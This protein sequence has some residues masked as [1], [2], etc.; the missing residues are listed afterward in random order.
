MALRLVGVSKRFGEFRAVEEVSLEAGER[1]FVVLL[2]P[3][4]SGKSTLLR[5]IAGLEPVSAGEILINGRRVD[6]LEPIERNI[7]FVFQ[8]YALYP[9]MTVRRNIAFPLIMHRAR[10][11][12]HLPLLGAV[13]KR[14]IENRPE[15]RERT[16]AVA[17]SIGLGDMLDRY[18]RTLSGGQ[19]QRVAVGRALVRDPS[20]FLMDEPLSN[21]DA[22]LRVDMRA[23]IIRLAEQV[24]RTFVYVTHDQVEAMTMASLVV[25]LDRGRVQQIG[26]PKEIYERPAHVFVARFIGSPPMNLFRGRR[27]GARFRAEE[28]ALAL[29]LPDAVVRQVPEGGPLLMGARPEDMAVVDAG[30]VDST[31][32]TISSIEHLGPETLVG[33][34]FGPEWRRRYGQDAAD[35]FARVPGYATLGP[36]QEV[37]LRLEAGRTA[38]F[39]PETGRAL[40]AP[41]R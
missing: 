33:F 32:A 24:G 37:A 29:A 35:W 12:H 30:T 10:L 2:G 4:G 3:S 6:G 39:S 31:R 28:G 34:V 22:Q 20:V 36:G 9:H 21:L 41:D 13:L 14:R 17:R 5:M 38:F 15:V 23:Q 27:E 7:A 26:T 1:D 8:T 18:P 11:W 19:R 25:V 40:G 16:E